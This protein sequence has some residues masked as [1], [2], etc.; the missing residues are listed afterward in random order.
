M[1]R[2][3]APII[4]EVS[5][6]HKKQYQSIISAIKRYD[7]IA[8]FRH[9]TPDYDAFGSQLGLASWIKDNF[10][11]KEVVCL[12]DNHVTYTPNVFPEMDR[13]N[14]EWFSKP[15]LAFIVDV[16]NT[17]RIADPRY[18]KAKYK[19][20][21]DHHPQIEY[22]GNIIMIDEY[23]VA[24][25]ELIANMFLTIKGNYVFSK[26]TA[27]YLLKGII[28]DSGSFKY[29][30]TSEHTLAI[31]A[32]LISKGINIGEVNLNMFHKKQNELALKQF[33]LNNY[34]ITPHGVAYYIVSY[35]LQQ[36][37]QIETEQGKECLALFQNV[38]GINCWLSVT[39]DVTDKNARYRVS[40]RS[41]TTPINEVCSHFGGGG[42][43]NASGAKLK[44]IEELD[45]LLK[46][47]D[48]LF[49]E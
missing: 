10:Q 8:I 1:K 48:A 36:Q 43:P 27:E 18:K 2:K 25:S 12:G 13:V 31:A 44:K 47:L 29:P 23:F 40:V 26:N 17:P 6:K 4:T 45:L 38:E 7:R 9:T 32:E 3:I 46:E 15:F 41:N 21:I 33:A 30:A 35:E 5:L 34:K 20:R 16:A 11:E 22:W 49:I 28:G 19:I 42:H 39:E 37:L 14:A 24:A